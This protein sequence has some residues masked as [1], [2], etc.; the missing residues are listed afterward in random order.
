MVEAVQGRALAM[1]AKGISIMLAKRWAAAE[2]VFKDIAIDG[3]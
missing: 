1:L 3:I 2:V